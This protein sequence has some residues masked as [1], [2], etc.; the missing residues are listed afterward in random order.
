VP[1]A[2]HF[3]RDCPA[4]D[5]SSAE[6]RRWQD[7]V[8]LATWVFHRHPRRSIAATAVGLVVVGAGWFVWRRRKTD[9]AL[10]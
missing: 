2:T 8:A 1:W 9:A 4:P 3:G 10:Q 6:Q 5:F 7:R